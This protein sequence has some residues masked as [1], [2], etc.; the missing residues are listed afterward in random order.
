MKTLCTSAA[1]IVLGVM[2]LTLLA[3][4]LFATPSRAPRG[5]KHLRTPREED[6][7]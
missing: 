4:A 2:F 5:P 7:D 6:H 3:L 1:G